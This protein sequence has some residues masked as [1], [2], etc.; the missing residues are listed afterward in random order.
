MPDEL[1]DEIRRKLHAVLFYMVE[2]EAESHYRMMIT[3]GEGYAPYEHVQTL[4]KHFRFDDLVE[5]DLAYRKAL[6]AN[7]L[8]D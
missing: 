7:R 6:F 4:I 5:L 8:P 3:R 1:P 2:S